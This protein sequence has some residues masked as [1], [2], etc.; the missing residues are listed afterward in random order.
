MEKRL[1]KRLP[2]RPGLGDE[3]LNRVYFTCKI[4]A[5]A[6]TRAANWIDNPFDLRYISPG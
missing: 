6:G 4:P 1:E 2:E 3:T 5:T